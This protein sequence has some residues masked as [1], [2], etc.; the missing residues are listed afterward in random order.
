MARFFGKIG[1]GDTVESPVNSGIWIDEITEYEYYGDVIKTARTL[2]DGSSL[3]DN[4]TV[5]N[6]ISVIADKQA[7]DHFYGIKYVEWAG[8]RWTVTKVDVERPRLILS[9]GSVYNGPTP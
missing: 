7:E 1:Y 5:Q 3:N 4:I 6:R 9:L 8:A 2:E